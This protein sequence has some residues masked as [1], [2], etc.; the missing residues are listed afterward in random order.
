[1][2]YYLPNL[3][4]LQYKVEQLIYREEQGKQYVPC[5]F[6]V[7]MFPQI[8]GSTCLGFDRTK[9]GGAAI[10]CSAMTKAYTTVFH[11]KNRDMFFIFFDGRIAYS[12]DHAN[13]I[14][15]EDLKNYCLKSVSD[16]MKFYGSHCFDV[17]ADIAQ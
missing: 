8:W 1:M 5:D 6:D 7:I 15:H 2:I 3:E 13:D 10:S 17:N 11:E 16:A 14:F 9:T 4:L 12:V